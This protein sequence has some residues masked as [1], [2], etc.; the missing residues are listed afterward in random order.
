MTAAKIARILLKRTTLQKCKFY[1]QE[2]FRQTFKPVEAFK[3]GLFNTRS[4]INTENL[5]TL[6]YSGTLFSRL[7]KAG[8][9]TRLKGLNYPFGRWRLNDLKDPCRSS[10]CV[11]SIGPCI[12]LITEE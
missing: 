5:K 6:Q 2:N 7:E 4:V 9:R 8:T 12:I 10:F 1:L 11:M 3:I